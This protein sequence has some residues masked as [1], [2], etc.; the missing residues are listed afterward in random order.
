MIKKLASILVV[1]YGLLHTCT[2]SVCQPQL[3]IYG[4]VAA[5]GLSTKP[6]VT[7]MLSV[8]GQTTNARVLADSLQPLIGIDYIRVFGLYGTDVEV[9]LA[10]I[11]IPVSDTVTIPVV[12]KAVTSMNGVKT[13]T[14]TVQFTYRCELV[15]LIGVDEQPLGNGLCIATIPFRVAVNTTDTIWIEGISK[16]CSITSTSLIGAR[17]IGLAEKGL[18]RMTVR[19]GELRQTGHCITD[20]NTRLI[21]ST[22]KLS[23]YPQPAATRASVGMKSLRGHSGELNVYDINGS[24]VQ[25]IA[26]G[27]QPQGTI[28]QE[29]DVTSLVNGTYT[30]QYTYDT[31]VSSA[32]MVIQR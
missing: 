25:R 9:A 5:T 7:T 6:A 21:L 17:A 15:D 19:N 26:V 2:D 8:I 20:G 16:L 30:V 24:I 14:G 18:T 28:A 27:A 1:A 10:N 22:V 3:R 11:D 29:L 31:G 32:T 23:I 13:V 4:A 12:V